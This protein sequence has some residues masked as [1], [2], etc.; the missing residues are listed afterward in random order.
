VVK[1]SKHYCGMYKLVTGAFIAVMVASCATDNYPQPKPLPKLENQTTVNIEWMN[2]S[3][4]NLDYPGKIIPTLYGDLVY[5]GDSSGNIYKIDIADG[6]THGSY[7]TG[8]QI[9]SGLIVN[10]TDIIYTTMQGSLVAISKN[11]GKQSWSTTLSTLSDQAP[12][13]INDLIIVKT[14][15]GQT[16]SYNSNNGALNWASQNQLPALSLKVVNSFQVIPQSNVIV[17]G[18]P[19]GRITI[20]NSITGLPIWD[21]YISLPKG[22]TELDKVNDVAIR[23]LFDGRHIYIANYNGKIV[24]L[25]S[26]TSNEVWSKDFSTSQG[27][28]KDKNNIYAVNQDGIVFAFDASTGAELWRNGELEYRKISTPFFYDNRVAVIEDDG[29]L[30]LFSNVDGT[31]ISRQST[32]L[33][34]GVSYPLYVKNGVVIQS[35]NG[36]VV[37]FRAK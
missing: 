14:I 17:N 5:A 37:Y 31:E 22:S 13:L 34:K 29:T 36:Y 30:H 23:P 11:T 9:S 26:G 21:T 25:D 27:I 24:A 28:I 16:W 8:S 12:Q 4:G 7:N 1:L 18:L 10:D 33:K 19:N 35:A 2:S 3:L 20:L 32:D 6:T 15:D